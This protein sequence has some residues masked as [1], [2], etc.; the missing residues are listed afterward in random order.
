MIR[1]ITMAGGLAGAVGL[2]Q[3]PE[4]SQQ[5]LQR[6]SGARTELMVIAKGFDFAAEAAGY[7]HEEA[8]AK[9]S[10]SEFQNDLR[11]QMA[12][13]LA[14]FDRLEAAYTSLKQT[15]PLMRLTKLWHFRDTDLV[16]DTW[17]EF[18]PAV[19]VTADGLISAGIGFVGG[20]LILSLV[21][22]VITMPFRRF[23]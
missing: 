15:E 19:P 2:S 21:L 10:G 22:G 3:F 8:L 13:N 23:A 20:W 9:M 16:Q 1:A 4:F 14:R 11:D 7:T 6:L 18:R 17:D 5:Y 12:G